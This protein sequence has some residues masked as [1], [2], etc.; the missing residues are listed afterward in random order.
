MIHCINTNYNS[1]V[2]HS[3]KY[4]ECTTDTFIRNLELFM[5]GLLSYNIGV[6]IPNLK[7]FN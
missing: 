6:K 5:R 7:G 2:G 1:W 3:K 4:I